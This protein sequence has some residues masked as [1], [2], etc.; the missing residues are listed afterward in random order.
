MSKKRRNSVINTESVQLN[1]DADAEIAVISVKSKKRREYAYIVIAVA[2]LLLSGI[3]F[4]GM[5]LSWF[6]PKQEA[7]LSVVIT[8]FS[9]ETKYS[10]SGS[11]YETLEA[12]DQLSV[13]SLDTLR[14]RLDYTGPS[15]A[16]IR[17]RLFESF[18]DS[19]GKLVSSL[20]INYNLGTDWV[21]KDGYYYYKNIV[22]QGADDKEPKQLNF[23]SG[24]T[25]AGTATAKNGV[26]FN[27]VAVVE[28]V[29]PDRF[30]EFFG[31][32]YED[33]FGE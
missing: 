6:S 22:I 2:V 7:D 29:Q 14:L 4:V 33:V 19:N 12:E 20:P 28:A 23:V 25:L 18:K 13:D 32:S 26:V 8:N 27:L 30:D 10:I 21:E 17:V 1:T 3:L 16:Y 5:A 15:A 11:A 31:T 24:A 9:T